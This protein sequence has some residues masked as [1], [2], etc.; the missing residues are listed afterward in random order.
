LLTAQAPSSASGVVADT[1][2]DRL[3]TTLRQDALYAVRLLA[4]QPGFAAV[5]LVTLA[6]GIGGATAIFSVV[7][8]VLLRPLPYN[9]ESRVI[10]VWETEPAAGVDKMVGTPGNFPDWRAQTRTIDHLGA[11]MEYDATLTGR[12][13]PRRVDGRR[14]SASVFTALGV[15]AL[16][17]RPLMPADE[18]ADSDVVILSHRSWRDLFGADPQIV[19]QRITLNDQP[20]TVVGV[21]APSFRLP[22]GP[23][24][25]LIPLVFTE[26]ER[27]Q[28]GSHRLLA[29][30]RLKPGVSLAQAQ[31]DMDVIARYLAENFPINA[32][33]GLLVEPIR[34]EM[35]GALQR[36][37]IALMAAVLVVMVIASINVAN[38]LLAR[39]WG[40]RQEM[41]VRVAMGAR[42]G[43]L[44][45][46]L[47]TEAAVLSL[48]GSVGGTLL[49]WSAVTLQPA[50]LPARLAGEG[51]IAVNVPILIF[52][53]GLALVSGLLF[54]TAP[55]AMLSPRATTTVLNDASRGSTSGRFGRARA[56]LVAAEIALAV[57]MLAAGGLLIRSFARLTQ[58]D[59]GF[60]SESILTFKIELPRS[61][62]ANPA[63]WA[64]TLDEL[65]T[66]LEALPSVT[67]AGAISWLPLTTTGGSN[68]LFVEGHPL[69]GPGEE[70]YVVYRLVTPGYFRT[71]SIPL[72]AG[73][74]FTQLDGIDARKVVVINETMA[75]KYWPGA[76]PLGRR[77]SFAREPRQGGW[78]TVV[79]VVADTK[80]FALNEPI[81]IEMFAPHTQEPNWFPPSHVAIRSSREP[82]ALAS[83][84]RA[85][86]HEIDPSMPVSDI[87]TMQA[88]VW[89][90]VAPARFNTTVIGAFAV[91]ALALA[92]VGVY[93]LLSFSVASRTREFGIRTALGA[94]PREIIR[95][96]MG[97]GLKIALLG[98]SIGIPAALGAGRLLESLLFEVTPTDATTFA[99]IVALLGL[100]ALV[101]CYVPA[102]RAAAIDPVEA[103]R[104]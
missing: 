18:T 104:E 100:V 2:G 56:V 79:G 25:F 42:R 53:V 87:K 72:R 69:P 60:G 5:T 94:D 71:L 13:E 48:A 66:R 83:A 80:Q 33:E 55:V 19:G 27:R 65:I 34:H 7:H 76:S 32:R 46:Q 16:L 98:L 29:I 77:A 74:V 91:V 61:R 101:A 82:L 70:T 6:L 37:L 52:A 84:A 90:S 4:R 78:M 73:R 38:L 1:P 81:D 57:V 96:V 30:G 3:M 24:D 93:G 75:K 97:D 59:P 88:V 20:R 9:D 36:P 47:L 10:M 14:V 89:G 17:G 8:A 95:L 51:D 41:A 62:Y 22:R 103:M 92:A 39:A 40:R 28:R 12:G 11:L 99:V 49:A 23:D 43:R 63:R 67:S 68:A 15:T 31:A 64:P 26:I 45:R 54:G 102:R 86:V 50:L 44:V 35:S 58:V 85:V 21:M